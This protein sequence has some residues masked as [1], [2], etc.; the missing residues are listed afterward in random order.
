MVSSE[1]I[2]ISTGGNDSKIPEGGYVLSGHGESMKWLQKNAI[3]G[4]TVITNHEK[5]EVTIILT[6]DSY[7]SRALLNIKSAQDRLDLAKLH[8]LD[9]PYDDVQ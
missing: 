2:I 7:T 1:G 3:L 9:I 5:K 4:S 6:P 8:Y